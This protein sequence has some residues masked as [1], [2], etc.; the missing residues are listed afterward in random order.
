MADRKREVRVD[1]AHVLVVESV[2]GLETEERLVG[3]AVAAFG[4]DA[5]ALGVS[6]EELEGLE[7]YLDASGDPPTPEP[8]RYAEG[9]A[10]FGP[11]SLPPPSLLTAASAARERGVPLEAL[12]LPEETYTETFTDEVSTWQ[13]FWNTRRE[14]K[15]ARNPPDAASARD[16]AMAWDRERRK[17]DGLARLEAKRE[18]HMASRL[19]DLAADNDRVLAVVE[20][21]RVD[22]IVDELEGA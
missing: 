9:L 22:G 4:P 1:G 19:R 2:Y 15:L 18:L 10:Q 6:P 20:T 12:D 7:E 8:D 13:L 21:A 11:I 5:V 16:Y 14:K 17:S 3:D